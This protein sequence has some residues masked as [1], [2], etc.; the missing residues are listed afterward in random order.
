MEN[1]F[2]LTVTTKR[3]VK[4]A[5]IVTKMPQPKRSI[6]L[7]LVYLGSV[8]WNSIGIGSQSR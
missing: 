2:L 5:A 1:G 8:D 7:I 4:A 3:I 6:K